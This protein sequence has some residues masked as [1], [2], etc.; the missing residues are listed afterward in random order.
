MPGP[1]AGHVIMGGT[2]GGLEPADTLVDVVA[3]DLPWSGQGDAWR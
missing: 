3:V 2:T 1:I